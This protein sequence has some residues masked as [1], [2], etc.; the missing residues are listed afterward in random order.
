MSRNVY[1]KSLC[2]IVISLSRK[3][4]KIYGSI[5]LRSLEQAG[6]IKMVINIHLLS[7]GVTPATAQYVDLSSL[8]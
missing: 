2:F 1:A 8:E 6:C 3:P 7:P 5:P 4:T